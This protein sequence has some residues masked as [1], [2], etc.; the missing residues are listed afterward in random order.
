[1]STEDEADLQAAADAAICSLL[2]MNDNEEEILDSSVFDNSDLSRHHDQQSSSSRNGPRIGDSPD[3]PR[4]THQLSDP[5]LAIHS[6]DTEL[7]DEEIHGPTTMAVRSETEEE[8]SV[9]SS[10]VGNSKSSKSPRMCELEGEMQKQVLD[11]VAVM[12]R[13]GGDLELLHNVMDRYWEILFILWFRLGLSA[14]SAAS[15]SREASEYMH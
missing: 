14:S 1:M 2:L 13:C 8:Y 9:V 6:L 10:E 7:R 11:L 12:D 4:L 3:H 15:L 5:S